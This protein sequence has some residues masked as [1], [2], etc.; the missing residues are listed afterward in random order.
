M[1]VWQVLLIFALTYRA[2]GKPALGTLLLCW[3]LIW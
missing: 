1:K 3:P 2:G